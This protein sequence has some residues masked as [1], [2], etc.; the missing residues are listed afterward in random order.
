MEFDRYASDYRR[1]VD[2]AAGVSVEGLAG[3][4][5]RLI[6]DVLSRNL[7]DAGSLRV[8]DLGCGIGLIDAELQ[9]AVGMLCG[10]DVSLES[11]RYA[12]ER[13]RAGHFIHYDGS[14]PPFA[15]GTFDAVFASCVLHH[16]P[17]AARPRFMDEMMRLLKPGGIALI[18]EHNAL[19]P[20]T[21]LIVSRCAFDADA[22]LLTCREAA[23][24]LAS[25]GA[26]V[27]GRRYVG[28]VPVRHTLIERAERALAWL[29]AGAQYCVWGRKV[30]GLANTMR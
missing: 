6:V 2:T 26:R 29:P 14:A 9:D 21:R 16:V 22:V 7:G 17:P 15:D 10:A 12:R 20:M 5:A 18:I 19:N 3:E 24:L 25:C 28:F 23:A 30:A 27:G 11:L 1:A 8:L 4:K 13:A